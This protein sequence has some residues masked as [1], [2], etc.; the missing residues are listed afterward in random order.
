MLYLNSCAEWV[1]LSSFV[2]LQYLYVGF[3]ILI[4]CIFGGLE[5]RGKNSQLRQTRVLTGGGIYTLCRV[6]GLRNGEK[7]LV[8]QHQ[9]H[10]ITQTI[11]QGVFFKLYLHIF[12]TK[13][14]KT[15]SV[16]EKLLL[17]GC[18][19]FFILVLKMCRCS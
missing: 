16:N 19:R 13:M 17:L 12:R 18:T 3:A 7:P 6:G 10:N 8:R 15:C 1:F 9:S 14:K 11:L 4:V 2:T 5:Y